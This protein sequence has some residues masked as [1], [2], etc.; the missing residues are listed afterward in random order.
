[1]SALNLTNC[2]ILDPYGPLKYVERGYISMQDGLISSAGSDDPSQHDGETVD[3][4]GGLVLPGLINA[5]THLYSAL[6][7]GMPGPEIAPTSFQ[8][9]LEQIWWR[10][11]RAL[12]EESTRA[13]FE[14]GM[15]AC[16]RAGVTTVVDHHSSPGF[17]RGS[18]DQLA[19]VAETLGMN[20]AVAFETSDRNGPDTFKESL[21]ENAEAIRK[22][23]N[24]PHMKPLFGLHA[25]FTLSDESFE[26]VKNLLA[27]LPETGIHIHLSEGPEDGAD[28]KKRGYRS[29]AE[30]LDLFGL[31]NPQSIVVH[32][33][34]CDAE[35]RQILFDRGVIL[36][37][38]PTSNANNR[39]GLPA[40][41]LLADCLSG[42][43]TDGMQ[44]N[45]LREAKEGYLTWSKSVS[46]GEPTPDM[47]EMLLQNNPN[48]VSSLFERS[49][50][51]I[52]EGNAADLV[53]YQY[54]SRT[55]LTAE[56]AGSHLL[57]GLDQAP[58][59]VITRGELR[60]R[61]GQP[62]GFDEQSMLRNA[63]E[64]AAKLWRTMQ[65]L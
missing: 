8:E 33:V 34:H 21:E 46:G 51:H 59:H 52:A 7:L 58:I 11:D 49:I 20:V 53:V 36:V 10:L 19:E 48:I 62:V 1:M 57:F 27:D 42:L 29:P 6:A 25:S 50:G 15:L 35:D 60:I 65:S 30:R 2:R 47:L 55:P 45:V 12:D 54:D 31:L 26:L 44:A 38:N 3:L 24:H 5:H 16:L 4:N 17:V 23:S 9:T 43:G 13:S 22:W 18:L 64:Q 14:S 39:V 56:N 32:G 63:R 61:D 41:D 28:A 40:Q 37:H